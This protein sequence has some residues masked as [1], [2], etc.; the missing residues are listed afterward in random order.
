MKFDLL[1]YL[2]YANTTAS[3]LTE[4]VS[5]N[6]Y[7]FENKTLK[8]NLL[9]TSYNSRYLRVP[10]VYNSIDAKFKITGKV[11]ID[12][13][14]D[15]EVMFMQVDVISDSKVYNNFKFVSAKSNTGY[16]SFEF[17]INS[18]QA[19]EIRFI[20]GVTSANIGGSKSSFYKIELSNVYIETN[21]IS[22]SEIWDSYEKL[23]KIHLIDGFDTVEVKTINLETVDENA[24]LETKKYRGTT[25]EYIIQTLTAVHGKGMYSRTF[26]TN[27]EP[28]VFKHILE[29]TIIYSD[30][31]N[32]SRLRVFQSRS[33]GQSGNFGTRL[34]TNSLFTSN[35]IEASESFDG[36]V[37][38]GIRVK[39]N[40]IYYVQ[41]DVETKVFS[42]V[43]DLLDT[44]YYAYKMQ[45][46]GIY[47]DYVA[48]RD[49]LHEYENSQTTDEIMLLPV[50]QEP[51]IPESVR[52]FAE[53]YK[54]I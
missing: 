13:D 37:D 17:S 15:E 49:E 47:G 21:G 42:T 34:A 5:V 19:K 54:L 52:E 29:N 28:S 46:E 53:K 31:S 3:N 35:Y 9:N 25:S 8:L 22:T 27:S 20:V 4:G 23:N 16:R 10:L 48:Y 41:N 2:M 45:Q 26:T 51:E 18:I 30:A 36:V 11:K 33:S 39:R 12:S 44:P 32:N 14:V 38:F 7:L 1:A 40:G 6:Q 24:I 50:L 43:Y